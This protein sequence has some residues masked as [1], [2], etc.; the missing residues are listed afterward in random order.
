MGQ[1][2]FHTFHAI[3]R[4]A[5]AE[6]IHNDEADAGRVIGSTQFLGEKARV[7]LVGEV[8]HFIIRLAGKAHFRILPG[9]TFTIHSSSQCPL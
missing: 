1:Q 4:E 8:Q 9:I 3:V 6:L 7:A 5:L 2:R